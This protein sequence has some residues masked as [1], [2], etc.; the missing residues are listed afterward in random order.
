MLKEG[1]RNFHDTT[2]AQAFD[3]EYWLIKAMV[4]EKVADAWQYQ[5]VMRFGIV[6]GPIRCTAINVTVGYRTNKAGVPRAIT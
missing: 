4:S 1:P 3:V 5:A 6:F 2:A